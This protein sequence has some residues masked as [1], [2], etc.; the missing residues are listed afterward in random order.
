MK[1]TRIW[2]RTSRLY[3]LPFRYPALWGLSGAYAA[4]LYVALLRAGLL[5]IESPF[6]VLS[7]GAL[8]LVSPL[9]HALLLPATAGALRGERADW[10]GVLSTAAVAYPRLL[11]GE[12]IVGAAA[13][14]GG[15]LLLIPGV[16]VGLRLVYYKQAIVLDGLPWTAAL[17]RS[18]ERTIEWRPI[19]R[20]FS[21]FVVLY[22]GALGADWL[23]AVY[24]SNTALH[25]GSV[26]A[27]ALLLGWL[28]VLVTASY[29]R[30]RDDEEASTARDEPTA[31][32]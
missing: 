28:N 2:E 15:M 1:T 3:L 24:A 20:L 12:L 16:Y 27:S 22:G 32:R 6:W 4:V 5:E 25:I 30:R 18:M 17:R 19:A 10:R 8:L 31:R 11:I 9:Y 29:V 13:A 23:L 26:V 7:V 21:H 14:A